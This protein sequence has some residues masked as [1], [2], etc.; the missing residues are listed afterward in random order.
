M[1]MSHINIQT[2]DPAATYVATAASCQE[3]PTGFLRP[4]DNQALARRRSR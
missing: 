4:D 3:K 1:Q 2:I